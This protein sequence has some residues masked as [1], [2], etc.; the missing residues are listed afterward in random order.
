VFKLS[1]LP[2]EKD[3]VFLHTS[4][5]QEELKILIFIISV[6]IIVS[7]SIFI[8]FISIGIIIPIEIYINIENIY[9]VCVKHFIFSNT[10]L[11]IDYLLPLIFY[12][13]VSRYLTK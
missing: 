12:F 7:I 5:P 8:P 10:I 2:W 9:K 11:K 6:D 3:F 4:F 13:N 1:A